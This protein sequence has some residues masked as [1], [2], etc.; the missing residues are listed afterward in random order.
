MSIN[1]SATEDTV[2]QIA[3]DAR[4]QT[5]DGAVGREECLGLLNALLCC[6]LATAGVDTTLLLAG[7]PASASLVDHWVGYA[8]GSK[9]K[10]S[11]NSSELHLECGV[12][13][14]D[15]REE[16]SDSE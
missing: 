5:R 9:G 8:G 16:V 6:L 7:S 12:R 13:V 1:W 11:E 15:L 10:D 14:V 4:E 3:Q 2:E